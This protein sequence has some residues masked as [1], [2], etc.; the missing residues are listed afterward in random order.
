M[1]MRA[2]SADSIFAIFNIYNSSTIAVTKHYLSDPKPR[3]ASACLGSQKYD[4]SS[5]FLSERKHPVL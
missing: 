1:Q 5:K 3:Q 2:S 4:E